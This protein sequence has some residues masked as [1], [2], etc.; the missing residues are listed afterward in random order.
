[1]TKHYSIL[2][3]ATSLPSGVGHEPD[4]YALEMAKSCWHEAGHAVVARLT[5]FPVAWVSIDLAFIDS[6]PLA[7]E[8]QSTGSG[9]VCMTISSNRIDPILKKRSALNKSDKETVIGYCMHV[10]AGPAA[11]FKL[12]PDDFDQR[13]CMRDYAQV[14]QL[15]RVL[16]PNK[17]LRKKLLR[18][19]RQRLSNLLDVHWDTIGNVAQA[20]YCRRTLRG[21]EIDLIIKRS[22]G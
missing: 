16:E 2:K 15:L 12:N 13:P 4:W 8:N 5:D 18:T 7:I 9:P 20:L 14:G 10:L 21:A 11:E 6:D 1:M 3:S 22:E 17:A 19:A